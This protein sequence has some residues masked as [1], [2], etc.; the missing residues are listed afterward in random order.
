VLPDASHHQHSRRSLY[1]TA[2]AP[3]PEKTKG[4]TM[5]EG[6]NQGIVV[7]GIGFLGMAFTAIYYAVWRK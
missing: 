3:L 6:I 5:I 1:F 4:K 7:A 2:S